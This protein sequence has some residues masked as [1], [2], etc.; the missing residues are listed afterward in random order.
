MNGMAFAYMKADKG[1]NMATRIALFIYILAGVLVSL[2]TRAE[3]MIVDIP[4]QSVEVS[5]DNTLFEINGH[6]PNP[7]ISNAQPE[8]MLHPE[9]ERTLVINMTG[10]TTAETCISMVGPNY[11]HILDVPA[12]KYE[13]EKLNRD[14]SGIYK[15]TTQNGQLST[16]I[17]LSEAVIPVPASSSSVTGELVETAAGFAII[18]KDGKRYVAKSEDIDL[19]E[20]LG[21]DVE[22]CGHVFSSTL[23]GY[24][25]TPMSSS[26]NVLFVTGII[27]FTV[28]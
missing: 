7:C 10:V 14:A 25:I 26:E 11:T 27:G 28:D 2:S 22:T 17:D 13:L 20:W 5:A 16:K 24:S 1:E 19:S 23:P 3:E 9:N 12:I 21:S 15:I 6:F 8:I 4:I 18:T